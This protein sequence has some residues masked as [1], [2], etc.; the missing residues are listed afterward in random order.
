MRLWNVV[1]KCGLTDDSLIE[2]SIQ[3]IPIELTFEDFLEF[4]SRRQCRCGRRCV[5]MG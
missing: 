3:R 1:C 2:Q 5:H 4:F